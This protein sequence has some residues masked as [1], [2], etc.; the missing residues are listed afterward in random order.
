MMGSPSFSRRAVLAA[1]GA[2]APLVVLPVSASV[3]VPYRARRTLMGTVVDITVADGAQA[4]VAQKVDAA[5]DAMQRLEAMMSRFDS[6]S[7]LSRMNQA[8]GAQA[9]AVPREMLDVLQQ[10]QA[11]S[12][13]TRGA[14]EPLLG[15]LTAQA[16]RD[17]GSMDNAQ[18]QR[19]LPH[20]R[21]SALQIDKR[22]GRARLTDPL[23]RIDLGGVAKLPILQAG[24][25]TLTQA[26]LQGCMI[27]GGGDVLASR[28]ADGQPWRIGVRDGVQ[29]DRLLAV[30]PLKEG[31]VAS[32]GD[33]ER[34][35]TIGGARYHHIIDPK[36]GRPT[37]GIHGVT[38]VAETVDQVNGLGTAAMVAGPAGASRSLQAWGA[39]EFIVMHADRQVEIGGALAGKLLPP[40]GQT[41]IRRA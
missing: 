40:P 39:P 14:F 41:A 6:A 33:Y 32:S 9:M 30:V 23:A 22:A 37:A 12:R 7:P 34:Y 10:G 25:D 1:L 16:D 26:G 20:A 17:V 8:A 36:T 27:N 28:R 11:L 5:F 24:L 3:S 29:P 18:I 35:I 13:K 2:V 21:S 38:L 4:G 19:L 31:I 15:R